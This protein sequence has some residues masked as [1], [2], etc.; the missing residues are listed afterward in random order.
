MTNAVNTQNSV[1]TP[2]PAGLAARLPHPKTPWL[3]SQGVFERILKQGSASTAQ[4]KTYT[5]CQVLSTDPEYDFVVKYFLHHKPA[6]YQ[7][8]SASSHLPK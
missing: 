2:I 8:R 3:I 7:S 1:S 6:G 4:S 5:T